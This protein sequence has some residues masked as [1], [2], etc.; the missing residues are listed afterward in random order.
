MFRMNNDMN[1]EP[2]HPMWRLFRIPCL[3]LIS[4]LAVNTLYAQSSESLITGTV[5]N[6]QGESVP[7]ASV[8]IFDTTQ[9]DLITGTS[10]D[11]T[12]DFTIDVQPGVM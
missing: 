5:Y 4:A 9:S 1:A 12:G 6:S 7:N 2:T 11:A 8:A 3:M 10:S